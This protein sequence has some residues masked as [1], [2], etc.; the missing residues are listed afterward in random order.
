MGFFDRFKKKQVVPPRK[1]TLFWR[2]AET[3]YTKEFEDRA[4]TAAEQALHYQKSLYTLFTTIPFAAL[5]KAQFEKNNPRYAA[6]NMSKASYLTKL[7]TLTKNIP[8][9]VQGQKQAQEFYE[10]AKQA[11]AEIKNTTPKQAAALS[12]FF[13]KESKPVIEQLRKIDAALKAYQAFLK[14]EGKVMTFLA[15]LSRVSRTLNTLFNE[16]ATLQSRKGP[17]QDK[18]THIEHDQSQAARALE[19]LHESPEWTLLEEREQDMETLERELLQ[20]KHQI[21]GELAPLKRPLKKAKHVTTSRVWDQFLAD[22]FNTFLTEDLDLTPI[23]ALIENGEL[24]LKPTEVQRIQNLHEKHAEL[25]ELRKEYQTLLATLQEKKNQTSE[26][27][28]QERELEDQA[29]L[30][31]DRLRGHDQEAR[32]LEIS[33]ERTKTA[34]QKSKQELHTLISTYTKEDI[35]LEDT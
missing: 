28:H 11:A 10:R 31:Q 26:L 16:E 21:I 9:P 30:L 13:P 5:E 24:T 18:R 23:I 15:D 3:V 32:S 14:D 4:K 34:I 29:R 17:L 6:V 33:I 8:L 35:T 20:K 25:A 19:Q 22:P 1:R 7:S 27:P 2:D 12:T